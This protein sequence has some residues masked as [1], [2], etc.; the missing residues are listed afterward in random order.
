MS[1][2]F[3]L[4]THTNLFDGK[5]TATEMIDAA[6]QCGMVAIGISNHFIVHPDIVDTPSYAAALRGGYARMYMN[7]FDGAINEFKQHYDELRRIAQ[8]ASIKILCG[9]E[10]DFFNT[11]AWRRGFE[12]AL[13]V[14][15]PDY[16]IGS[17]HFVEY[18]GRL[19]NIHDMANAVIAMV[20]DSI[21]AFVR[22]DEDLARRV[23]ARDDVVD[24]LFIQIKTSLIRR[25][26]Q[27]ETDGSAALDLLMITKYLERIGDHAVNVA[28]WVIYSLTGE[29]ECETT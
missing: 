7:N 4:H 22:D 19:C 13:K 5:N 29:L 3:T 21:D 23:I 12:R 27:N 16:I 9:M 14:L 2:N 20:T 24:D 18:N 8:H 25:L 11:A 1:Q 28:L 26:Q 17:G 6:Q 15:Q 10:V